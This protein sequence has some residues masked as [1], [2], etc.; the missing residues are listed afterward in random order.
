MDYSGKYVDDI[1][2]ALVVSSLSYNG[3]QLNCMLYGQP[4]YGKT[5]IALNVLNQIFGEE[6]VL[7]MTLSE[8]S[9]PDEV[10]GTWDVVKLHHEGTLVRNTTRTPYDHDIYAVLADEVVRS[11]SAVLNSFAH[12]LESQNGH[13]PV[14]VGTANFAVTDPKLAHFNNR[15]AL[16]PWAIPERLNTRDVVT[17]HINELPLGIS[18][19]LPTLQEISDVS[20]MLGGLT[21]R[22]T[23]AIVDVIEQ[24]ESEA[25]VSGFNV[26]PRRIS[27]WTAG[28]ARTTC[29]ETGTNDFNCVGELALKSL[30]YMMENPTQEQYV[31]WTVVA[32]SVADPVSVAIETIMAKS[33]VKFQE[34]GSIKDAQRRTMQV[35]ELGQLLANSQS[36]LNELNDDRAKNAINTLTIWFQNAVQGKDPRN[37]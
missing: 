15:F 17:S 11:N 2:D 35:A 23:N 1:V 4:G 10:K 16:Q 30:R 13:K 24:L 36:T 20:V 33:L 9:N 7:F 8:D 27:M 32:N 3:R 18:R 19:K 29:W 28:L 5:S 21:D 37:G 31:S 12:I 6:H 14:I 25:L 26:N 22:A 34:V